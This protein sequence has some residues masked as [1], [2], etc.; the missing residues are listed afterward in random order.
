MRIM[1]IMLNLRVA[2]A[3]MPNAISVCPML[4]VPA[5]VAIPLSTNVYG[6]IR[7]SGTRVL[8]DAITSS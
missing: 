5:T 3:L 2:L 4:E 1:Y 7:V 8:L 6:A